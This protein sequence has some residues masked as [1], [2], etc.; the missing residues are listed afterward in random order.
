MITRL[1]IAHQKCLQVCCPTLRFSSTILIVFDISIFQ[2]KSYKSQFYVVYFFFDT[3]TR[4]FIQLVV[5]YEFLYCWPAKKWGFQRVFFC[6]EMLYLCLDY[7]L[8][9]TLLILIFSLFLIN[10][11][12]IPGQQTLMELDLHL[13]DLLELQHFQD[14]VSPQNILKRKCISWSN[15]VMRNIFHLI[16]EFIFS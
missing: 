1:I 7:L 11:A 10:L 8:K 5:I 6:V 3:S 13:E 15:A 12:P 16:I 2:I 4:T 9:I 14:P